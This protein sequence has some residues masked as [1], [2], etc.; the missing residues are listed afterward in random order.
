[1]SLL[2]LQ[3]YVFLGYFAYKAIEALLPSILLLFAL[4]GA[5]ALY[6]E[7]KRNRRP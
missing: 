5:Y 4:V 7:H 6:M 1:M 2:K 3:A